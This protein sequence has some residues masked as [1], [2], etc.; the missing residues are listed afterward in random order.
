MREKGWIN[1]SDRREPRN[2]NPLGEREREREREREKEREKDIS[3]VEGKV[4]KR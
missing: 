4:R 2:N 1:G 3:Y